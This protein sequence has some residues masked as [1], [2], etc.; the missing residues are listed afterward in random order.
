MFWLVLL[1]V[2]VLVFGLGSVLKAAFWTLLIAA[3]VVLV[4]GI[5][6]RRVLTE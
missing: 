4:L 1:I 6:V 3:A 5:A 2:L